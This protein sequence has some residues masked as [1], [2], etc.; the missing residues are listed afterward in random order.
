MSIYRCPR[1]RRA[2]RSLPQTWLIRESVRVD[3]RPWDQAHPGAEFQWTTPPSQFVAA[4]LAGR[5]LRPVSRE[6]RPA[7]ATDAPVRAVREA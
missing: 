5:V 6:G 4:E 3:S 7:A 2:E 1:A